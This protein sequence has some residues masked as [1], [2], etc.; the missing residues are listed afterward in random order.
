MAVKIILAVVVASVV[1]W[2]LYKVFRTEP[3]PDDTPEMPEPDPEP[4]QKDTTSDNVKVTSDNTI[5]KH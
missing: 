4:E 5:I 2:L 3:E 1:S